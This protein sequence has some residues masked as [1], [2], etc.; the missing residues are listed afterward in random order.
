MKR[1][2]L[3]T[4]IRMKLDR[5]QW[6]FHIQWKLKKW[7]W[8]KKYIYQQVFGCGGRR[9]AL[10]NRTSRPRRAVS[11]PRPA[12]G[13]ACWPAAFA[14]LE[15]PVPPTVIFLKSGPW[16]GSDTRVLS[17]VLVQGWSIVS[18]SSQRRLRRRTSCCCYNHQ[19]EPLGAS[20]SQGAAHSLRGVNGIRRRHHLPWGYFLP[21][22]V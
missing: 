1:K 3:E 2:E 5:A 8:W 20:A 15:A 10:N 11:M 12:G 13:V 18:L 6:T 19:S 9:D 4:S 14:L 21:P 22:A 7:K 16:P 17:W